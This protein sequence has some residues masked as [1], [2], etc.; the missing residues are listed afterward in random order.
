MIMVRD[1]VTISVVPAHTIV[2]MSCIS[3]SYVLCYPIKKRGAGHCTPH[4]QEPAGPF[5]QNAQA[6]AR[7]DTCLALLKLKSAGFESKAD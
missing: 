6:R 4:L 3:M 2:E 1:K 7:K 5:Q